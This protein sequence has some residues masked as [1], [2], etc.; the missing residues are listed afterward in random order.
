MGQ[1]LGRARQERLVPFRQGG[2]PA[3]HLHY[4]GT[5]TSYGLGID[6]FPNPDAPLLTGLQ[7][8]FARSHSDFEDKEADARYL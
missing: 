4:D 7:L 5:V 3:A 1:T 6:V 2:A 8:A